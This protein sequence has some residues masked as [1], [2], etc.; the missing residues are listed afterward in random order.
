VWRRFPYE[1]FSL[2]RGL[3]SHSV[4]APSSA[5]AAVSFYRD[6]RSSF[7]IDCSVFLLVRA[8]ERSPGDSFSC[9][10]PV[11]LVTDFL[12]SRFPRGVW[13]RIS[14]LAAG[15]FLLPRV[16]QL[17]RTRIVF[18]FVFSVKA[19]AASAVTHSGGHHHF[20]IWSSLQC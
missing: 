19:S 1:A 3:L 17:C 10:H 12:R 2:G 15:I 8:H 16:N 9:S 4:R 20:W 7:P 18:P 5:R 14:S 13:I 6:L 11:V